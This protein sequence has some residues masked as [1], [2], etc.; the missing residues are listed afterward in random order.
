MLKVRVMEDSGSSAQAKLVF[1][2]N[3]C[4]DSSFSTLGCLGGTHGLIIDKSVLTNMTATNFSLT[5][6]FHVTSYI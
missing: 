2:V 4:Q 5:L 3:T 6:W 1:V